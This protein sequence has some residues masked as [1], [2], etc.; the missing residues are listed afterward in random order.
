MIALSMRRPPAFAFLALLALLAL[1]GCGGGQHGATRTTTAAPP[2]AGSTTT[3]ATTGT[4]TGSPAAARVEVYLLQ[5]EGLKAVTRPAPRR[6]VAAA[7]GALLQGPTAAESKADVR[8]QV[9]AGT[10]L[11]RASVAAGTATI[12]LTRPYVEGTDRA[13]LLARL[14]QLVWTATAIPGVGGVRLWI[15]GRAASSLGRGVAVD[16]VL[17]RT[18]VDPPRKQPPPTTVKPDRSGPAS[19]GGET[20]T[21]LQRRLAALGYLPSAAITGHL[22]PWTR[23]AVLAFQGWEKLARDGDPGPATIARLRTARRP[24]AKGSGRRIEVYIG[25]QVALLVDRGRV[26]RVIKVSTGAP[27]FETPAGSFTIFRKHLKDWSYPYSVWL[28]YASYFNG[29]I[30]FHESPDVPAYPVSHGCVRVPRDD[31]RLVY[32]FATLGTRVDVLP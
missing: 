25:A 15:D 31:A 8:T 6:T 14:A 30:A 16:R 17:T 18:D 21:W 20:T 28:P 23:G 26:R 9:P 3:A 32:S 29:G 27:G 5:G 22:G 4:A 11:R 13:S 12:D 19:A 10:A 7:V 24:T 1:P 2:A